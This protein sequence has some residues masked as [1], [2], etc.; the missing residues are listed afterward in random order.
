M[1]AYAGDLWSVPRSGGSAMRLTS[2]TGNEANPAFSPD[3]T[4]VAFTGEYDGNVDVFVMPASGGVPR[5]LTWH[6][7]P[8]TVLGWTPDGNA[9]HLQLAAHRLL[10]LQRD[11]HGA[12]G[13]RRRREAPAAERIRSIDVTGRAVDRLRA[14]GKRERD[15]EALSRR[16]HDAHLA[17]AAV[18]QHDHPGASHQ[19]QRLQSHVGGRP[20]VLPF[21][22]QRSRDAVLVRHQDE[23]GPGSAPAI[24][25]FDLK[26][27][28]LGPD[29][30]VYEQFAGIHLYDLKSGTSRAVPIRV[31]GD[32]PELRAALRQRRDDG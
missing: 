13:R 11:V 29:A 26:S 2:G 28:S 3:G 25:S 15:V 5:R 12:G 1:F 4:Q 32:L 30:I 20:P 22:S 27:A 10:A 9:H 18:G 24:T 31:D 19:F 16:P 6:P 21:R 7:A 14:G 23:G 17:R 8:D